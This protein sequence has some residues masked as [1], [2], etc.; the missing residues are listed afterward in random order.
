MKKGLIVLMA[1]TLSLLFAS[2]N[3]WNDCSEEEASRSR[4]KN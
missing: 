2:C 1:A 3:K 4:L